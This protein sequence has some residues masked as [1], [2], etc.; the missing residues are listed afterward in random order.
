MLF[1]S[2]GACSGGVLHGLNAAD[3]VREVRIVSR[4]ILL[5][6][7]LPALKEALKQA[8]E[9]AAQAQSQ[10]ITEVGGLDVAMQRRLQELME[11]AP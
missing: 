10:A 6:D 2:H 1:R 9:E 4:R 3:G 11:S 5:G 8:L 7:D